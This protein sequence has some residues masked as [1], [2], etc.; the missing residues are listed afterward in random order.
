MRIK[1]IKIKYNNIKRGEEEG[2][3][4]ILLDND[5][6]Y[7]GISIQF[8]YLQ[9]ERHILTILTKTS[10]LKITFVKNHMK[11]KD[12]INTIHVN[13]ISE[14]WSIKKKDHFDINL[15]KDNKKFLN[16]LLYFILCKD[17]DIKF[18]LVKLSKAYNQYRRYLRTSFVNILKH[19]NSDINSCIIDDGCGTKRKLRDIE[20]KFDDLISNSIYAF[21][22]DCTS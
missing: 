8:K 20:I 2:T 17:N 3:I 10:D 18:N 13:S 6:N 22:D 12:F 4:T 7:L 16:T 11:H 15:G 21:I 5:D 19:V 1:D 9:K 14:I